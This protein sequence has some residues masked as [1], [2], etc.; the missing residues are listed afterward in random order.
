MTLTLLDAARIIARDY[1]GWDETYGCRRLSTRSATATVVPWR[2]RS[3]LVCQGTVGWWDWLGNFRFMP[4]DWRHTAIEAAT[5]A[6]VTAEPGEAERLRWHG[7]WIA[8]ANEI[9]DWLGDTHIDAVLGHSRGAGVGAPIALT[10]KVPGIFFAAPRSLAPRQR[11][12][13][14]QII[15]HCHVHDAVSRVVPGWEFPGRVEWHR[16]PDGLFR[17]AHRIRHWVAAL[18][19]GIVADE[20]IG[21]CPSSPF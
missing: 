5:A 4:R 20:G 18:E 10:R 6:T 13:A 1:H 2:G 21:I 11:F 7:D 15:N 16:L 8:E 17:E 12:P 9:W 14:S 19:A 3:L